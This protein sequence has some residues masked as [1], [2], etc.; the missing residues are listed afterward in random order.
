MTGGPFPP[1]EDYERTLSPEWLHA[2]RTPLNQILGYSEM[3]T[4]QAIEAGQNDFVPDL[5]RIHAAGQQLLALLNA[6][7]P[8]LPTG[9]TTANAPPSLAAMP[10]LLQTEPPPDMQEDLSASDAPSASILIV[11]DSPLNRDLLNRRLKQHGYRVRKAESGREA[12][13]AMRAEA[14]DLVLLDILMP[15]MDG[16]QVLREIKADDTLRPIPVL[17]ISALED[18]ESIARCIEMGAEDYLP[19]PSHPAL[20]KA[21]VR[22]SLD[23]KQLYDRE[24]RL[25]DQ[26]QQNRTRLEQLE[27]LLE[28]GIDTGAPAQPR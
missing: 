11:D 3:L 19:K 12:I 4:E 18:M 7:V 14:F 27:R 23:R 5:H 21:R 6:I 2:L 24:R 17:M 26:L 25:I 28:D 22:A 8:S 15:D 1:A 13:E 16:Y 20:F 9:A 10:P